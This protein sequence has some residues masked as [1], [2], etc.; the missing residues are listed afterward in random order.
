MEPAPEGESRVATP[1]KRSLPAA[2][3]AALRPHQWVKNVLVF[4]GLAF[5]GRWHEFSSG[6][7]S[8]RPE[9]DDAVAAAVAAFLVFCALS[10][11]GYLIN[12]LRDR[13]SDRRHPTKCRRPIA[14]G[15]LSPALALVMSVVLLVPFRW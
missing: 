14:A 2:M 15:E 7:P 8:R 11:A 6:L 1:P 12:D 13:E 3:L 10:S 4:G 9:G 5:T